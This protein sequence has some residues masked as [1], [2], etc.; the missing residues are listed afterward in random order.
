MTYITIGENIYNEIHSNMLEKYPKTIE[1]PGFGN[2]E[3]LDEYYKEMHKRNLEENDLRLKSGTRMA[4]RRKNDLI[5]EGKNLLENERSNSGWILNI[6]S[7]KHSNGD[8][9]LYVS[10]SW[11]LLK[12]D[13]KWYFKMNK[14]NK[15]KHLIE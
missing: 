3:L 4:N 10:Q 11:Y 1:Y 12:E 15:A 5:P 14:K 2:K 9:Y 7:S 8:M 13:G 6:T